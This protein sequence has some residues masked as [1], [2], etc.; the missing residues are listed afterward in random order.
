MIWIACACGAIALAL[1]LNDRLTVV[2]HAR[3]RLA[4]LKKRSRGL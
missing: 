3:E 1:V 2:R 4:A